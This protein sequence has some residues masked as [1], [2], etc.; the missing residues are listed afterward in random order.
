MG[1]QDTFQLYG[2]GFQNKLLAVLLKNR[3]YLQQIHDIIEPSYF[4]SE[5][6][7]WIAATIIKYF[8]EYKN[9]PSLDVF[10]IEI[11]LIETP[12]LKTTVVEALKDIVRQTDAEDLTYI[13]D[14]T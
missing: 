2:A 5:A 14:K 3:I 12:V 4:S 11:D 10:K 6:N 1:V 9:T 7:Q 8:S 13:K